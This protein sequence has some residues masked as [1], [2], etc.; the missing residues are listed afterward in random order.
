VRIPSSESKPIDGNNAVPVAIAS[1]E[2]TALTTDV[3][4]AVERLHRNER[5]R[6][7]EDGAVLKIVATTLLAIEATLARLTEHVVKLDQRLD[8]QVHR[9]DW[10]SIAEAASQLGKAEFTVREWCRHGRISAHKRE[11]GR[12]GK[13]E[14]MI[15]Q[16]ELERIR[17]KGL[18]PADL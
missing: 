14:W 8:D 1:P 10:Y 9:K 17:N 6:A 4:L 7:T 13:R 3:R 5:G 2:L 18:L 11:C 12:G 15:S 16:D